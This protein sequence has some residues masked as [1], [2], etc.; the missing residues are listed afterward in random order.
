MPTLIRGFERFF[1][2]VHSRLLITAFA[3]Q[4]VTTTFHNK[5]AEFDFVK[6]KRGDLVVSARKHI[7]SSQPNLILSNETCPI[8]FAYLEGNFAPLYATM[9]FD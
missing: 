2:W 3:A 1:Q 8:Q 6:N 9:D 4:K 5:D 7:R